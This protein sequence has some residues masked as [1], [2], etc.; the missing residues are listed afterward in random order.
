MAKEKAFNAEVSK[1]VSDYNAKYRAAEEAYKMRKEQYD[2]DIYQWAQKKNSH[3]E[4]FQSW[5]EKT[6]VELSELNCDIH[7][8]KYSS[9]RSHL[10]RLGEIIE[11][12]EL[13][14]AQTVG[15]AI[16]VLMDDDARVRRQG[17]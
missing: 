16:T 8:T 13:G 6:R 4:E 14:R 12:L 1:Y 17:F 11:I 15:G 9:V 7:S 10:N 3:A 2:R 5:Q